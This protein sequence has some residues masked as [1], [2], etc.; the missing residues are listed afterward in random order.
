[1]CYINTVNPELF[2]LHLSWGLE[3]TP[4]LKQ[5]L[6]HQFPVLCLGL[7][8]KLRNCRRLISQKRVIVLLSLSCCDIKKILLVI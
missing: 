2:G 1:M 8:F 4:H 6:N 7:I 5:T 3:D